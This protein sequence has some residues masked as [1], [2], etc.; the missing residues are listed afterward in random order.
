MSKVKFVTPTVRLAG[1]TVPEQ[2]VLDLLGNEEG[3]HDAQVL[4]ELGGRG[5]Y[6]S[7]SKPNAKT[8]TN[9]GYLANIQEQRHFSVLEHTQVTLYIEGVSRSLLAEITRHR[10]FGFSVLSQRYVDSSDVSFILP[11]AYEGDEVITQRFI[12]GRERDLEDYD[13]ESA[14]QMAK[15]DPSTGKPLTKKQARESAR[16]GLPNST[17]TKILMSGNLRAWMEYVVKRDNPAADAEI[18]RLTKIIVGVLNEEAPDVFGVEARKTWD[19]SYAQR[20]ARA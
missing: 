18:Q 8:A 6:M 7:F 1:K 17:E 9:A 19:D 11:P 12:E 10:H 5:C 4:P 2:W 15:I 14:H 20:M 13:W 3:I 16:S